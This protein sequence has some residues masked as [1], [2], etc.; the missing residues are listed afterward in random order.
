[1]GRRKNEKLEFRFY[2]LPRGESA[3]ALLGNAWVGVYG[4]ADTCLHFH[5]LFE[6]GYCHYGKGRLLLGE[7]ELPYEDAMITAI[8]ANCP[9]STYSEDV[10]SW[11]FLFFDP[12]QLIRELFPDDPRLRTELLFTA[13]RRP[14]LLSIDQA[15]ELGDIVWKIL[16]ESR[17][18]RRYY[19][20]AVRTLLKLYLLELIRVQEDMPSELPW[21]MPDQPASFQIIPALR[22][23]DEHYAEDLRAADLARE[24]GLSEPHFRRLFAEHT[25]M[26][27]MDYLNLIRVR[28]ACSLMERKD[29]SMD[30]IAADCG[31]SSVSAFT[32]NFK[33]FLNVTP[34]QWKLGRGR[35]GFL[36]PDYRISARK[37]WDSVET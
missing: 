32:R 29:C 24:C 3:L 8:P 28:Q 22:Y 34:Y 7:G 26:P 37:G 5:N 17:E 23:I 1:M 16:E 19:Q 18:K 14:R 15:P 33:K 10:D 13:T 12:E 21:D 25:N 35:Q 30:Q 6:I 27:P 2:E 20:D 9:H 31:F 36:P 4:R 11:E